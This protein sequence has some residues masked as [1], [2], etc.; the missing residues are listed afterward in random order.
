MQKQMPSPSISG[1]LKTDILPTLKIS[2]ID[3]NYA[4]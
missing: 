4:T 3:L 1:K 2:H